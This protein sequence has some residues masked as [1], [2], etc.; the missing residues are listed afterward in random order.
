MQSKAF[1]TSRMSVVRRRP[2]LLAGGMN[3]AASAH[4]RS[5]ISLGYRNP[6]RLC[7]RRAIPVHAMT[8][9]SSSQ[10]RS[11]SQNLVLLVRT[12]RMSPV[13]WPRINRVTAI[14]AGDHPSESIHDD[15]RFCNEKC[16][17]L[18]PLPGRELKVSFRA[19]GRGFE[20]SADRLFLNETGRLP[21]RETGPPGLHA[22]AIRSWQ[23]G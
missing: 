23:A 8:H 16:L 9:S 3:G 19:F 6:S 11:E 10:R 4:S 22:R 20:P 1:T 7:S 5:V 15:L 12:Q 17:R 13:G 2:P 18:R 14:P 21:V